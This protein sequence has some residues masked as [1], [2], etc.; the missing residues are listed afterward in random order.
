MLTVIFALA[1]YGAVS[2]S[3]ARL[4]DLALRR[5]A[6]AVEDSDHPRAAAHPRRRRLAPRRGVLF[7]SLFQVNKWI[8][9]FGGL[10]Y[11]SR[12][13]SCAAPLALFR[14]PGCRAR[15]RSA[16]R[17]PRRPGDAGRAPALW[18]RR[19]GRA[20]V[21]SAAPPTTAFL[22]VAIAA[23]GLT[24]SR[25]AHR[26]RRRQGLHPRLTRFDWRPLPWIPALLVHLRSSR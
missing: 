2:S 20:F 4:P 8:W 22:L 1:F 10:S 21:T 13:R 14:L 19:R 23:S 3:R 25:R 12:S 24:M 11:V 6:G 7:Q 15:S 16:V 26:R 9:L 18:G 17:R 5:D